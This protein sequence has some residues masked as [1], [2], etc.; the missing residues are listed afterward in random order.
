MTPGETSVLLELERT[1]ADARA[2]YILEANKKQ[3]DSRALWA[4]YASLLHALRL[5]KREMNDGK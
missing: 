1:V 4:E 2:A 5:F 3:G